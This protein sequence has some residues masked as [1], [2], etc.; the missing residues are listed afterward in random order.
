MWHTHDGEKLMY[1]LRRAGAEYGIPTVIGREFAGM[2]WV[3]AGAR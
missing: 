1:A 3:K 2:P